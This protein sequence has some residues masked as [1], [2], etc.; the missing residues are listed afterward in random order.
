MLEYLLLFSSSFIIFTMN[1]QLTLNFRFAEVISDFIYNCDKEIF[2]T[3]ILACLYLF[4]S[5]DNFGLQVFVEDI[6]CY[7]NSTTGWFIYI[8]NANKYSQQ[9][10]QHLCFYWKVDLLSDIC[11]HQLISR[12]SI[13][14]LVAKSSIF[15]V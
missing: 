6:H 10:C 4:N 8:K 9:L 13:D 7:L 12:F 5:S 2:L 14:S 3:F 11:T 1:L 15:Y